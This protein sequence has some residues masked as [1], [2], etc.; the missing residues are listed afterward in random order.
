MTAVLETFAAAW[1][2]EPL[3]A[4]APVVWNDAGLNTGLSR[5][6]TRVN[7]RYYGTRTGGGRIKRIDPPTR[8]RRIDRVRAPGFAAVQR[9]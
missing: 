7:L 1:N 2:S 8:G 5:S 6:R 3:A 9:H 4:G